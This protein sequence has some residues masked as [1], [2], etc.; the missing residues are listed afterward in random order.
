MADRTLD[1]SADQAKPLRTKRIAAFD[2]LRSLGV[3]LV[4]LH[5][6]VLAYVTFGFLNPTDPTA[7]F[8]PIVDST[9]WAGFDHIVLLNDTFFMPLLFFV[10]DLFV[11]QSLER[12][13]AARFLLDR[14]TRLGILDA[15]FCIV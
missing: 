15:L 14:L 9:K 4:L 11:W 7:T 6:A 1:G 8:S 10:S 2:Y 5:H 3:L 12:K 13:G